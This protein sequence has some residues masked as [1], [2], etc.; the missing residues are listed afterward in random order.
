M[1]WIRQ[2]AGKA[3]EWMGEIWY[4]ATKTIYSSSVEGRIEITRDNSNSMV[5]L[6]LSHLEPEDSAVF[7]CARSTAVYV[8]SESLQKLTE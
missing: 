2:S 8:N 4:D 7:Y 6:K 5:F 3:L 1:H